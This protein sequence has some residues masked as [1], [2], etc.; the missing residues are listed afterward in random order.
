VCDQIRNGL[1]RYESWVDSGRERLVVLELDVAIGKLRYRDRLLW[2]ANE[3]HNKAG[4]DEFAAGVC[5]DLGLGCA[6][7]PL[8]DALLRAQQTRCEL[9]LCCARCRQHA[10]SAHS[11]AGC[12]LPARSR[13]R[14]QEFVLP[15]TTAIAQQ[16]SEKYQAM[17]AD[18]VRG[19]AGD[20]AG[21]LDAAAQFPGPWGPRL[22]WV[23]DA[24]A[25]AAPPP[26]LP[27]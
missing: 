9:R 27:E 15:I 24:A 4:A 13:W 22:E 5:A 10:A 19:R 12:A 25:Q 16:K 11:R 2:D 14:R 3:P 7:E 21:P 1:T 23:D 17:L 26:Q 6:W 8:P 18:V 20:G